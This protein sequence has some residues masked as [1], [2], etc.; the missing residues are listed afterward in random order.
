MRR[1][2]YHIAGIVSVFVLGAI[3]FAAVRN[4]R[5]QETE[6]PD[7]S[8]VPGSV[9]IQFEPEELTYDGEGSLDLMEGVTAWEDGADITDSVDAV[10]TGDG[11]PSRK[12]IRYSVFDSAGRA[13]SRE[14]TLIMNHYTGPQISVP[15]ALNFSSEHLRDLISWLNEQGD[16]KADNGYGMDV[17]DRVTWVREK[18]SGG[19]YNIVFS[20]SNEF[21][22][23]TEKE[24]RAYISGEISDIELQLTETRT[25]VAAGQDFFPLDYVASANDPDY[26]DI[27]GRL[28]IDNMVNMA[29][30]GTYKVIYTLTSADKTQRAEAVLTVTVRGD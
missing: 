19:V 2:I 1:R 8:P 3:V 16:L 21:L 25:E 24:V 27:S 13:V 29:V 6:R 4:D 17:T 22:D 5:A 28:Q 9:E 11:T 15:T 30:P 26:G 14:R 18:V 7:N 20:L 12:R 23:R 10:L